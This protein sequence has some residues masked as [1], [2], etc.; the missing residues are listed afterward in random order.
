MFSSTSTSIRLV[1]SICWGFYDILHTFKNKIHAKKLPLFRFKLDI[2]FFPAPC[3]HQQYSAYEYRKD[4]NLKLQK[5]L[6]EKWRPFLVMRHAWQRS[7]VNPLGTPQYL[8]NLKSDNVNTSFKLDE[9]YSEETRSQS[10]GSDTL[11]GN[12]APTFDPSEDATD[13]RLPE[14]ILIMNENER[15]GKYSH[16][17]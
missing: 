17:S 9:G 13:L 16:R 4:F 14:W 3:F 8:T 6:Q 7:T 2:S 1:I 12:D 15:S 10:G 5:A 11:M